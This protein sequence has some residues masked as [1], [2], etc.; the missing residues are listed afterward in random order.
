[1]VSH[2][3]TTALV[4]IANGHPLAD[5]SPGGLLTEASLLLETSGRFDAELA[6]KLAGLAM[7][8]LASRSQDE[9]RNF[10]RGLLPVPRQITV[11]SQESSAA[12][13]VTAPGNSRGNEGTPLT[14]EAAHE[15]RSATDASWGTARAMTETTAAMSDSSTIATATATTTTDGD[16]REG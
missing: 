7:N 5:D 3:V 6:N 2:I 13:A 9:I 4:L 8:V 14:A 10:Q 15:D 1:M 16:T 11:G 12:S